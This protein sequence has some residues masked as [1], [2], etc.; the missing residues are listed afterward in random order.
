M[1]MCRKGV[2]AR[3]LSRGLAVGTDLAFD[4]EGNREEARGMA[5]K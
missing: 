5:R 4:E 1:V 3:V 2:T